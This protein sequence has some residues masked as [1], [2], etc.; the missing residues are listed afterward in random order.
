MEILLT[1]PSVISSPESRSEFKQL[2][3]NAAHKFLPTICSIVQNSQANS[4]I[5]INCINAIKEV[6]Q[7][8]FQ[9]KKYYLTFFSL[10]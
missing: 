7:S 10:V 2:E 6:F 9:L 3:Q 8:P 5:R 1:S 4:E